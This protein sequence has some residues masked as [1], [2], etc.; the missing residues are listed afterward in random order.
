MSCNNCNT[1]QDIIVVEI[2]AGAPGAYGGPQGVQGATGPQGV[3]GP[4]GLPSTVSGPRGNTGTSGIQGIQGIQGVKGDTGE[5]GLQGVQGDSGISIVGATGPSGPQGLPSTVSGPKGDTGERGLQ[6]QSITGPQG[7]QGGKG[8]TGERGGT[9][10]QGAQ[11]QSITGPSG[12]QGIQGVK[13]DTGV[14]GVA[15]QSITGP[16]GPQGIQGVKGDTGVGAVGATGLSITGPKGDTGIGAKGDTGERGLQGLQG[17]SGLSIVGSTG[18][19]GQ[20]FTGATGSRGA[21]GSTGPAGIN[22]VGS[23]GSTGATGAAFTGATGSHGATGSTGQAGQSIIGAT[24]GTGPKGD[25]GI[26]VIGASGATGAT[27]QPGQSDRYSTTSSSSISVTIGS[28]TLSVPTGLAWTTQQPIIIANQASGA[29]LT[30]YVTSYNSTTGV[31]IAVIDTVSGAG[32]YAAWQVNL[33]GI[34]GVQGATGATGIQGATGQASTVSGPVGATGSTGPQSIIP[35]ATGATGA[36]GEPG[37]TGQAFTGATGPV[38]TVPGPTGATGPTGEPGSGINI[39]APVRVATTINLAGINDSNHQSLIAT[40]N[41]ALII[42]GITLNFDDELLV[43]DQTLAFN[44]GVYVVINAGSSTAPW[45]LDR[46]GD[47]NSNTEVKTGDAVSVSSGTIN[48]GSSW[49]LTTAG[50]INLGTTALQWSLYSK[51]GATGSTGPQGSS[52]ATGVQGNTGIGATGASGVTTPAFS[53]VIEFTA[54]G[55][56]NT[57]EGIGTF[58][59]DAAYVV[60]INGVLQ[61]ATYQGA[62]AYTV[63]SFN[64]GQILF[65]EPPPS[66]SKI[67]VRAIYGQRGPIGP[68]GALNAFTFL[69]EQVNI[70]GTSAGGTIMF[71]AGLKS[72]MFFTQPATSDWALNVRGSSMDTFGSLLDV[73]ESIT[74]TLINTNGPIGYKAASFSIDGIFVTPKF[75]SGNLSVAGSTDSIEAWTYTMIKTDVGEYVVFANIIRFF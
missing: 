29:K 39:K 25:N 63:N 16:S 17:A 11:G 62:T 66:G 36:S 6:G 59:N 50:N 69:K 75:L 37:A 19:T 35:G 45:H 67:Q 61:N 72:A 58:N 3:Q 74:I 49:Y 33:N 8:D 28:K 32:T 21:T 55:S 23:T 31:L 71:D 22:I 20:A 10:P 14:Q 12:P 15:G 34:A 52:G 70:T 43:K 57:F 68:Q 44:N 4:S 5:R 56:T 13:G 38:S 40:A 2:L 47:S 30:G 60:T 42:D 18:A 24:G 48:G 54:D 9:G 7:V 51:I 64:G 46:R 26:S 27:G 1:E 53:T 41:E 73:S 65:T